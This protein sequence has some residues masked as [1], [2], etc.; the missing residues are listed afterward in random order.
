MKL[1]TNGRQMSV[2]ESL[3]ELATKKL[4]R[5][6][7]IF[8]E[9]YEA[10]VT[11]SAKHDLEYVEITIRRG[12][13]IFRSE[14]AADTFQNAMDLAVETLLGQIRR[15]KTRLSRQI[16][17]NTLNLAQVEDSEDEGAEFKIRKKSFPFKP[18]SVEEAILQMNLLGHQ[19]YVFE[20]SETG[21]TCVVYTRKDGAYGLIE[22]ER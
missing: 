22:P 16:R 21:D 6:D 9:E 14:E 19:F 20:N 12:S 13:T 1:T 17:D 3:K 2:R 10:A 11:F 18:M 15:N 5:F 4:A 7:R 8:G